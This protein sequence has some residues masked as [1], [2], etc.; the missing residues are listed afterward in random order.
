ML[1]T[2]DVGCDGQQTRQLCHL[3]TGVT[4]S[5]TEVDECSWPDRGGCEQRCVNTLGSYKCAC[6]PGYELA[7]DK[8]AC[9]GGCWTCHAGVRGGG[10][11]VFGEAEQRWALADWTTRDSCGGRPTSSEGETTRSSRECE[12]TAQMTWTPS[13]ALLLE[14]SL[15]FS[16]DCVKLTWL[17]R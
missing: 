2:Q 4:F 6:D 1:G 12:R 15:L 10:G 17:L 3:L 8:K 9:E 13:E 14:P 7:A 5:P 16:C 11:Q